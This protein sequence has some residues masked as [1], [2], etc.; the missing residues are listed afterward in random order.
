FQFGSV[1]NPLAQSMLLS[2]GGED[3]KRVRSIVSPTFSTA[4]MKR[5]ISIIKDCAEVVVNNFTTVSAEGKPFDIKRMYG[6][7]TMDAIAS[8]AFSTKLDSLN[9]PESHFVKAAKKAFSTDYSWRVAAFQLFPNLMKFLKITI[10]PP[11]PLEFFKTVTLRIIEE[12]RKTGQT[13]NDFLQLLIDTS[14]ETMQDQKIEEARNDEQIMSN[15][16]IDDNTYLPIRN[17]AHKNLSEIEM[18]GQCVIFFIAG[19]D[20]TA[21][22]LACASYLLALYPE[23]QEKLFAELKEVVKKTGS[24]FTYEAMQ[25]MKYFDNVIAETLR[26]YPVTPRLERVADVDLKL[27][28]ADITIPRDMIVTI[29]IYPLQRD[30]EIYPNPDVFDPDRF[31]AE[32]RAKRDPY[33][34]LPF[35]AG[36]RNCVGMR[37]ALMEVK[38]CLAYVV[39]NFK[40]LKCPRTKIP[41]DIHLGPGRLLVKEILLEVEPREEKILLR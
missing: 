20:T 34:Y 22:T 1:G 6:A 36:P 8:S 4:K 40:L 23:I 26:L 13:R 28:E 19:Y 14:K 27:K 12:R 38:V 25:E 30:P 21:N 7:F 9:D 16:N 35:G 37:F 41:L 17:A 29:P 11:E 39:A 33:T 3:W 18:V 5:M 24:E 32:E 10:F 2:L 31:T 15:Y